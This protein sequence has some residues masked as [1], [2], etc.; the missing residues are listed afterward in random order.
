MGNRP[1]LAP[2]GQSNGPTSKL[3]EGRRPT[4]P[5]RLSIEFTPA[6]GLKRTEGVLVVLRQADGET[7]GELRFAK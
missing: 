3:A 6:P 7:V 5:V 1:K 2:D 4:G